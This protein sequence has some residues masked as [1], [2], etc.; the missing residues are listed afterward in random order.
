MAYA[1]RRWSKKDKRYYWR[2]K[3]KLPN[4]RFG[5]ASKDD[6]GNKFTT[7][8][9]AERYGHAQETDVDRKVFINPRDGKITVEQWSQMWLGSIDL[10]PVSERGYRSRLKAVIVP[11]WGEKAVGDVSAIA[12]KTWIKMLRKKYSSDHVHGITSTMR[13][14]FDDAVT[15]KLRS[16]NPVPSARSGR[17]GRYLPRPKDEK[18]I[19]TPR[20]AL[21][22]ARNGLDLFGLNEYVLA[23][24]KAYTGYR[25]GEM[26]AIHRDHLAFD[27]A[28]EGPR[29][30]MSQQGQYVDGAF[31]EIDPKYAS[32]RGLIIPPFLADLLQRLVDSRPESP[33][34]FT[35]P[36]GGR[37]VRGGGWYDSVWSPMVN[38][39]GARPSGYGGMPAR[40]AA[41]PVLGIEGLEPHGL[42]HSQKVWL[43]EGKHP[44][45]AVE[46]RLGHI[47]RGVEG[48]YSH[49]TLQMELEIADYLQQLWVDSLK[50]VTDRRE[51]GPTPPP[52]VVQRSG[53]P[54]NRPNASATPLPRPRSRSSIR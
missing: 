22:V 25:I 30:H 34:V 14:M 3:F 50:P 39:V 8:A 33:W 15:E 24:T 6:F 4:G 2:V 37:L 41:R 19:A 23:L 7:E 27:N 49:V 18:V 38:G 1:E 29:I 42:R 47:I 46:A 53:S 52:L 20:Q 44:R 21:L 35:A 12:V 16:D 11:E 31:T 43:D 40:A 26:S 5:S 32:G 45:V 51:Y 36:N 48:V 9:L 13:V 10:A 17:R 28:K 54:G